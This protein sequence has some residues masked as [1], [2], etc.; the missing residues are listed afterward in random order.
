MSE[1]VNTRIVIFWIIFIF[2]LGGM[3][4]FGFLNKDLVEKKTTDETFVPQVNTENSKSCSTSVDGGTIK[5]DFKI[6]QNEMID[7]VRIIYTAHNGN[8]DDHAA[9]TSIYN[10]D[11][12]GLNKTLQGEYNNFTLML[13]YT[14]NSIDMAA[15]AQNQ[16]YFDKLN[17]LV[18]SDSSYDSYKAFL[19]AKYR[20]ITCD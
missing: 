9:A 7:S 6:N 11:I 17:I 20:S 13:T 3:A 16:S 19:T 1:S 15:I 5:Y 2:V 14:I 12:L 8:I 10:A 4:L 18:S